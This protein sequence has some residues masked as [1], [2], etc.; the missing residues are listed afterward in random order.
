M[1][2]WF[3]WGLPHFYW[4]MNFFMSMSCHLRTPPYRVYILT[5]AYAIYRWSSTTNAEMH[6]TIISNA[7]REEEKNERN[8]EW[9]KAPKFFGER[10][11]RYP[12]PRSVVSDRYSEQIKPKTPLRLNIHPH[13]ASTCHESPSPPSEKGNPKTRFLR[14]WD[15]LPR[16]SNDHEIL[17][18]REGEAN[19]EEEEEKGRKKTSEMT[20]RGERRSASKIVRNSV[21]KKDPSDPGKPEPKTRPATNPARE[22]EAQISARPNLST[23]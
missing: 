14:K 15:L 16:M 4:A 19:R 10:P 20:N 5:S 3:C 18:E 8:R 22:P 1:Y 11:T 9:E 2:H 12:R 17:W 6:P 13:R 21:R 23:L 7:C